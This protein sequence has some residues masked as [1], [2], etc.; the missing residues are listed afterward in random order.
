M[1]HRQ[2]PFWVNLLGF[3]LLWPA[4]VLGASHGLMTLGWWVLFSMLLLQLLSGSDWKKD[5]LLLCIGFL[6]CVVAEGFWLGIGVI[7]YAG[8][9][10][11]WL[12]PGWIWALWGGFAVSFSHSLA[13]LKGR[14][15]LGALFGGIGGSCSVYAG[16]QLGAAQ[17]PGGEWT[18]VLVYGLI[19]A[20]IVPLLS[21]VADRVDLAASERKARIG[22]NGFDRVG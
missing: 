3:Q 20:M 4:A 5:G 21:V 7:E 13:W 22:G 9:H 16:V 14:P 8:G 18:L 1:N 6:A 10:H 19:W 2:A 12:A 15:V 17:A 11:Q